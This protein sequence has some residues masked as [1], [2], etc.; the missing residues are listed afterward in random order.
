[1]RTHEPWLLIAQEDLDSAKHLSSVPFMTMLFHVQQCAEK[2]FK[3]Y[4]I[5][6]NRELVKTHDLI[7][8][9][10]QCME[11]EK[12]FETLRSFASDLNTYE[13]TGRY[14][15]DHF[16]R[17]DQEK[18]KHLIKQSESVLNYVRRQIK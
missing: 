1:M 4:L 2:S 17:P 6:K 11:F 18:M 14:P 15:D 7:K 13:T 8:L 16:K 3:A 5:F 12:D 10:V 9:V